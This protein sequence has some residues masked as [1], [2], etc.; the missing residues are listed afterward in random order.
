MYIQIT[1]LRKGEKS[2]FINNFFNG[3]LISCNT[4]HLQSYNL[5]QIGCLHTM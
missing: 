3:K 5:I 1:G 2:E 4:T